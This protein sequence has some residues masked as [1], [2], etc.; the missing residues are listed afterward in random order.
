M[1]GSPPPVDIAAASDDQTYSWTQGDVVRRRS[2]GSGHPPPILAAVAEGFENAGGASFKSLSLSQGMGPDPTS[3]Q[4]QVYQS[5]MTRLRH[6]LHRQQAPYI[7]DPSNPG[8][9]AS[10]GSWFP[11]WRWK[12]TGS[13][14]VEGKSFNFGAEAEKALDQVCFERGLGP[15]GTPLNR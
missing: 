9:A 2:S 5:R 15:V 14:P 12:S 13:N 1:G 3:T 7:S 10:V 6:K 11:T 4:T 8:T